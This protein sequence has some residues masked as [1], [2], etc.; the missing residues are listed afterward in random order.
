MADLT[1]I[2]KA[3][4]EKIFGMSGGYVL[5]FSNRTFAESVAQSTGKNI[6]GSEYE[7]ESGS[8][9]NRL[10]AF[11]KREPNRIVG[12]LIADLLEYWRFNKGDS[13]NDDLYRD[14]IGIAE[15]LCKGAPVQGNEATRSQTGSSSSGACRDEGQDPSG[16]ITPWHRSRVRSRLKTKI[17]GIAY[18]GS[19][20]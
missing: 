18:C 5:D 7:Y 19:K 14:C 6:L 17:R 20:A 8:K 9:A 10:R 15:Q 12:K 11:S 13:G 2:Q 16:V 3:K 1:L 4:L